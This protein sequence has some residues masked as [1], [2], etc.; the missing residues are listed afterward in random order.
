MQDAKLTSI[1]TSMDKAF[2]AAGHK[3]GTHQYKGEIKN[4]ANQTI[5]AIGVSSGRPEEDQEVAQAGLEA[6]NEI[7]HNTFY[8]SRAKL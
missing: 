2:S 6:L 4:I 7:L 5:G 8:A 1:Q 3:M